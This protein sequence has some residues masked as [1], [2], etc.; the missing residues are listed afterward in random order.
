MKASRE[1]PHCTHDVPYIIHNV[2]PGVLII[3][4]VSVMMYPAG[5]EHQSPYRAFLCQFRAK[6]GWTQ[7]LT[8]S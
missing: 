1:H 2:P 8:S 3:S 6:I 5:M 7:T 4:P